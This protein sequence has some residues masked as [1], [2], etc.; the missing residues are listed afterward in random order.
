FSC[1]DNITRMQ[2]IFN[3]PLTMPQRRVTLKTEEGEFSSIWFIRDVGY[4]FEASRGLP[5]IKEIQKLFNSST[6]TFSSTNKKIDGLRFNIAELQET[7]KSLRTA[8]HW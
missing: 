2:L 1:I 7:I 4:T 8:C 6:L 5:G 3:R